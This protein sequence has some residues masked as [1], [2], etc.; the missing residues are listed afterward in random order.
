MT[1]RRARLAGATVLALTILISPAALAGGAPAA[2]IAR[3]QGTTPAP[4][5][6]CPNPKSCPL[7][8]LDKYRWPTDRGVATIPFVVNP[9]QPWIGRDAALGAAIAAAR[10]WSRAHSPVRFLSKGTTMRQPVLGDSLNEIG[11]GRV[12]AGALAVA[13]T[14]VIRGKVMEADVVLNVMLPWTW[15][16]CAHRDGACVPAQADAGMVQRFDVQAVL[17]HEFGHWLGLAHLD[18]AGSSELTMYTTP[19][20]GDRKQS[21]LALGD[22]RGIR[23]AYPC[24]RCVMPRIVSP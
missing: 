7:Y 8:K 23:A 20:P 6:G 2:G 13:N 24:K 4:A 12:P 3:A 17:T 14:R 16:E 11:W 15:S 1:V 21:T 19:N 22:V 18:S 9:V 10:T 5:R